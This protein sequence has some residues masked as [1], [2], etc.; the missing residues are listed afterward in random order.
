MNKLLGLIF[1]M[2]F[3]GTGSYSF[4]QSDEDFAT[5][6]IYRV[7]ESVM[8]GGNSLNVKIFFNDKE[9]AVLQTNTKLTYKLY[10]TGSVKVRCVAGFGE[11][12]VGSPYA[13]TIDFEK[14]KEYHISVTAGSMFGVKGELVDE[15]G[16][17]KINKNE[18]S[19]SIDLVEEK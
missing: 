10:S 15:K 3:L 11:S 14:G 1:M 5:I 2:V 12:P 13:Q 9:L 8:S 7:K 18:F 19:D 16:L 17:K 6:N 4:G